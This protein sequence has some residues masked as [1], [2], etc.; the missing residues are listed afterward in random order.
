MRYHVEYADI[1]KPFD[2]RKPRIPYVKGWC[3]NAQQ[4]I[5]PPPVELNPSIECTVKDVDKSI[6][7]KESHPFELCLR[8]PPIPGANGPSSLRLQINDTIRIGDRHHVQLVLV[9]VLAV[10]PPVKGLSQGQ[11]VVAKLYDPMYID[12][13]QFYINPFVAADKGY[14]YEAAAYMALADFQSSAISRYYGSY[15]LEISSGQTGRKRQVRLIL[16]DFIPGQSMQS[17]NPENI[18]QELRQNLM[19]SLIEFDTL[20]YSRNIVLTDLHPRNIIVFDGNAVFVDFA[21]TYIGRGALYM[22]S[23]FKDFE[24]RLDNYVSPLLRWNEDHNHV[25]EFENW[26][27]DWDWQ[28]WLQDEFANTAR[29]ITPGMLSH[30]LPPIFFKRVGKDELEGL[31]VVIGNLAACEAINGAGAHEK[32][33][34][35]CAQA[36]EASVDEHI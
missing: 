23:L 29:S 13:D 2:E 16:M 8:H 30:F 32:Q 3:F 34:Q 12:D 25:A 4:H 7:M 1:T 18:P 21:D 15:S 9:E 27:F 22:Q 36:T 26:Y 14:T 28:P 33:L 11:Q 5:P 17:L 20:V 19:K 10:N 6:K 35:A 24:F 31:R